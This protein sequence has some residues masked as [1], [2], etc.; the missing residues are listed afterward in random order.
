MDAEKDYLDRMALVCWFGG[1]AGG[2]GG[3]GL[4]PVRMDRKGRFWD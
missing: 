2:G 1:R 4:I 3:D